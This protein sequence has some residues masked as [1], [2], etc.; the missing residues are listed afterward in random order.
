VIGVTQRDI[1]T[2][3]EVRIPRSGRAA[4]Y[5]KLRTTTT[6]APGWTLPTYDDTVGVYTRVREMTGR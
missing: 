2:R 1:R 5:G 4:A 6:R 3:I